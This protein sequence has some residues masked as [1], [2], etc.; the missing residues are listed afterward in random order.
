[1]LKVM[2][3][4]EFAHNDDEFAIVVIEIER[5]SIERGNVASTL[6]KLLV[7]TDSIENIRRYRESVLFSVNGYDGTPQELCEIP[8]VKDFFLKLVAEWPF[9]FWFL[10][11]GHRQ[12]QILMSILCEV[13]TVARSNS[14]FTMS[15]ADL[16]EYHSRIEDLV[17]RG[18]GSLTKAGLTFDE[19]ASSLTSA[20]QELG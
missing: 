13:V 19:E 20:L 7:L 11:R 6:E 5:H 4:T 16:G 1:M 14:N 9:W 3:A 12:V 10:V 2:N 15:Y 17:V 8:E 18:Y